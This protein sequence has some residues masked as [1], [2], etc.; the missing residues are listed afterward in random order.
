VC[1][2]LPLGL[3]FSLLFFGIFFV[4][5]LQFS[6]VRDIES[7]QQVKVDFIEF[8]GFGYKSSEG[9]MHPTHGPHTIK[10]I[11]SVSHGVKS[12]GIVTTVACIVLTTLGSIS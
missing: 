9:V 7:L 12:D 10:L 3:I 5:M 4:L 8:A 2:V 11:F 1:K 6:S